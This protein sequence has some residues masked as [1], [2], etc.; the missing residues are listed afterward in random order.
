MVWLGDGTVV[1]FAGASSTAGDTIDLSF[2]S[3]AESAFSMAE[4]RA[5]GL[6]A[7]RLVPLSDLKPIDQTNDPLRRTT[8]PIELARHPDDDA[9]EATPMLGALDIRFPGPMAVQWNLPRGAQRIAATAALAPDT[10]PWGDCEIAIL[11]DGQE[12][13]R[14]HLEPGRPAIA[15]NLPIRGDSITIAIEAGN[16]GP[17]NDRVTLHR[18]L[19]LL[20]APR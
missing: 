5:M 12:I 11:V 9:G 8:P 17:I 16:H 4:I 6:D 20:A 7:G 2:E 18:P 15:I 19:L 1:R 13:F 10:A 14:D 3:G